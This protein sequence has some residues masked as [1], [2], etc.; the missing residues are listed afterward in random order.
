MK[1]VP[2]MDIDEWDKKEM[3]LLSN[4]KSKKGW[5]KALASNLLPCFL[6]KKRTAAVATPFASPE[7]FIARKT[8]IQY[9]LDGQSGILTRRSFCKFLK[10]GFIGAI[11]ALKLMI[12]FSRVQKDFSE[13]KT[14]VNSFGFWRKRLINRNVPIDKI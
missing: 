4:I 6:L 8:V 10:Y 2:L 12:S 5:L 1:L 13:R 14:A 9:Q 7:N 3:E 11:T